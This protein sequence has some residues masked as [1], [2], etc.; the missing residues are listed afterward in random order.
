VLVKAVQ[1][2]NGTR[3]LGGHVCKGG[4]ASA[5]V[6][7]TKHSGGDGGK[8]GGPWN[9]TSKSNGY[10]IGGCGGAA[11]PGGK[12][13]NGGNGH[14]GAAPSNTVSSQGLPQ[15]GTGGSASGGSSSG[16]S[17]NYA[18]TPGNNHGHIQ[19]GGCVGIIGKGKSGV[20]YK[21]IDGSVIT[22]ETANH[23]S[24]SFY[25]NNVDHYKQRNQSYP[26]GYFGGGSWHGDNGGVYVWY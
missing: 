15:N 16:V 13:G 24:T 1:G 18:N 5:C 22:W 14:Y 25:Y 21:H 7:S 2:Q 17:S 20:G 19:Q 12:G 8:T 23:G 6:G 3:T 26:E 11:G 9:F 4:Q 10:N